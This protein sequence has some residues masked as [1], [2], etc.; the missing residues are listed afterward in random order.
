MK[1][2]AEDII[3]KI[4]RRLSRGEAISTADIIIRYGVTPF[5][6]Q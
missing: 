3:P 5:F 2:K 6:L 1:V 4:L